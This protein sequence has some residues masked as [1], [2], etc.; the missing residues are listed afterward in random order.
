MRPLLNVKLRKK[1]VD[2]NVV[3]VVHVTTDVRLFALFVWFLRE[4]SYRQS[5]GVDAAAYP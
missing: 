4:A 2:S 3:M 1:G 5:L